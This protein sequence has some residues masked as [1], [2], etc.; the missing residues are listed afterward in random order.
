MYSGGTQAPTRDTL[1]GYPITYPRYTL[2][3]FPCTYPRYTLGVVLEY[4]LD[5][6]YYPGTYPRYTLEV[7][8]YLL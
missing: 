8:G 7:L 2:E 1:W 5:C 6:I 3:R 4:I